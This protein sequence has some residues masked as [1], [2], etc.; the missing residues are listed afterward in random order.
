MLLLAATAAHGRSSIATARLEPLSSTIMLRHGGRRVLGPSTTHTTNLHLAMH[1]AQVAW[2]APQLAS[3]VHSAASHILDRPEAADREG[4]GGGVVRSTA[5][6][7][8]GL[9]VVWQ[10]TPS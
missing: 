4:P 3:S 1:S 6:S 7:Q 2:R 10:W 5:R 9:W 8:L